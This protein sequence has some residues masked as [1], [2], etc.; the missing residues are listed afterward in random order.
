MPDLSASRDEVGRAGLSRQ[1]AR[2]DVGPSPEPVAGRRAASQA[3]GA[4][5]PGLTIVVLLSGPQR[6][7][8]LEEALD[9]VPLDSPHLSAMHIVH[10][11]G[12]WDWH[13]AL[14]ARYE[15]DP[16]V[17]V[18]E[19]AQRLDIVPSFNRAMGT[20]Q[21]RW[22]LVLPDDDQL[23]IEPFR[24]ALEQ[25]GSIDDDCGM[26]SFGWYEH[27]RGRYVHGWLRSIEI[28]DGLR[29]PPLCA[30]MYNVERLREIGG[31][32]ER[33]AAFCDM[34][35][36]AR[37]RAQFGARFSEVPIGISRTH[38][39]QEGRKQSNYVPFIDATCQILSP[40]L[41]DGRTVEELRTA[42]C[43][44]IHGHTPIIRRLRRHVAFLLRARRQ[45]VRVV[46]G[47]I[48][49]RRVPPL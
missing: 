45:P 13:P 26:L 2:L 38:P 7:A 19:F 39:N 10:Q 34:V 30:T 8:W 46:H 48:L 21:S 28:P 41:R 33:V 17:R 29:V 31:F 4:L 18:F 47:P 35:V 42:V 15:A 25:L 5:T 49:T 16:K 23:I 44:L 32:D 40:L 11:G 20:V 22:A 36:T 12:A 37:L 9:S 1:P 3:G 24:A 6:K 14:R 43:N 27:V